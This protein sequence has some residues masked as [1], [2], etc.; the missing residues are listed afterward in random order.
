MEFDPIL[1]NTIPV[2]NII[3]FIFQIGFV[4]FAA[5][6]FIFSLI[7]IR[8]VNLMTETLKTETSFILKFFSILHAFLSLAVVIFFITLTWV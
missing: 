8:Q 7:I 4:L 2:A 3:W 1:S 5:L 6:Y